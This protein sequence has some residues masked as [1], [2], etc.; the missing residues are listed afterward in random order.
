MPG[1]I[2]ITWRETAFIFA[3]LGLYA[4]FGPGVF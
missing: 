3:L 2:T 4:A 1:T